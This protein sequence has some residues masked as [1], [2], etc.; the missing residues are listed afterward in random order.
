MKLKAVSGTIL[1]LLLMGMLTLS[2]PPT[3][4]DGYNPVAWVQDPNS[5]MYM[6]QLWYNFTSPSTKA[7]DK[8]LVNVYAYNISKLNMYQVVLVYNR[9]VL[10]CT[11]AWPNNGW[12]DSNWVFYDNAFGMT[13][14]RHYE[15]APS[16]GYNAEMVGDLL[17]TFEN[18]TLV[19]TE[20][21]MARF[22]FEILVDPPSYGE[23]MSVLD[24]ANPFFGGTAYA[25]AESPIIPTSS[26]LI[27][28]NFDIKWV[29]CPL[30]DLNEDGIVNILDLAIVGAA[31]GSF[32]GY[33]TWNPLADVNQDD[34]VNIF[35]LAIVAADFGKTV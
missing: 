15:E 9:S 21:L 6:D 13:A 12:D 29:P 10:N 16:E 33:P 23:L 26:Y 8:F 4:G 3:F 35:D 5:Q 2:Y 31:F 25:Y 19:D 30:S 11:N 22:E 7:G 18:I 1:T 17:G 20:A 34:T 14:W 24:L 32:P 27:N 28:S